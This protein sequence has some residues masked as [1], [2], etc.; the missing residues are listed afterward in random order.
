MDV[1]S[2]VEGMRGEGRG[3]SSNADDVRF[4]IT[5]RGLRPLNYG[6]RY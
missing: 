4:L 1:L 3:V 5:W 2:V 6:R